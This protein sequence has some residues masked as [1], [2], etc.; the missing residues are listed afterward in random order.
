MKW[1]AKVTDDGIFD[2]RDPYAKA[3]KL[4]S[5]TSEERDKRLHKMKPN[6]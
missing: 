5:E 1:Y 3:P 6:Q 2:Y 4:T